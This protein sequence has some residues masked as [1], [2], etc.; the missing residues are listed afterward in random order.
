MEGPHF[1][2]LLFSDSASGSRE[3]LFANPR[4]KKRPGTLIS[5]G[6]ARKAVLG[7]PTCPAYR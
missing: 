2:A 4:H 3:S 1:G 7:G 6:T 5:R